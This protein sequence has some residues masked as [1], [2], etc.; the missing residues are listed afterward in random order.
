V[1]TLAEKEYMGR[2]AALGCYLCNHLGHGHVPAQVHHVR[3]G[4]GMAQRASNWLTV[5]LCERHHAN[6]S[7][8]GWHGQRKA[9][10]LAG[11]DEMDALAWTIEQLNKEP[12][13]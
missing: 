8:D 2:V 11:K 6:Y 3:E 13:W 7:V 5:P 4:Q 12:D 9:W 1:T 10:K